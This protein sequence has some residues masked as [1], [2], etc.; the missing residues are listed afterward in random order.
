[1]HPANHQFTWNDFKEAFLAYHIPTNLL[2]HKLSEFLAFTQGTHTVLQYA[3]QFNNLCQYAG[4]HMDTDQKKMDRF[5][6]GLNTKLKDR[7]N[8]VKT[9]TYNELVNLAIT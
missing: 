4:Y 2:D 8:P 1:M 3:Q 9:A 5:H 6:R 7:L